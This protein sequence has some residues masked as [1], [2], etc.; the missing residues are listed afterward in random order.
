MLFTIFKD[1]VIHDTCYEKNVSLFPYL[2]FRPCSLSR[3]GG[4]K[5]SKREPGCLNSSNVL[6]HIESRLTLK[7][8]H[9]D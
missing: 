4:T 9:L 7:G 8:E 1:Y 3:D 5:C 6:V 2:K